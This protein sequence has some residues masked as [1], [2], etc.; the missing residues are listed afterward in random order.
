MKKL[1]F[2]LL[3]VVAFCCPVLSQSNFGSI[4]YLNQNQKY[5]NITLGDSITKNLRKL[6]LLEEKGN[7]CFKCSVTEPGEE[8][9][10]MGGISPF[11]AFVDVESYIIKHVLVYF[12]I[13]EQDIVNKYL[14]ETYGEYS[15]F[16]EGSRKWYG[17]EVLLT[18]GQSEKAYYVI[19]TLAK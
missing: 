8:C 15:K 9:Y 5:G 7:G 18:A 17:K 10:K 3:A 6:S 2:M 16:S 12:K 4:D 14:I 19:F 13:E 1:I 11:T